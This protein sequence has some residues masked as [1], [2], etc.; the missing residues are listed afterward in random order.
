MTE[1]GDEGLYQL[2]KADHAADRITW[3]S[4]QQGIPAHSQKAWLARHGR[5]AVDDNL[6]QGFHDSARIILAS[7]RGTGPD[8]NDLFSGLHGLLYGPGQGLLLVRHRRLPGHIASPGP[9]QQ[10]KDLRVALNDL[11][12][13][14]RRPGCKVQDL[15][16]GGDDMH[17]RFSPHLDFKDASAEQGPDVI[18]S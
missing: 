4:N 7:G 9:G 3:G 2:F 1:P 17:L 8:D 5:N 6:T 15:I 13:L 10:S 16:T 18:W 12:W 14:G 11:P